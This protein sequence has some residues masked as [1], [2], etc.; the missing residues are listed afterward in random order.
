MWNETRSSVAVEILFLIDR[1]RFLL[2]AAKALAHRQIFTQSR[3]SLAEK[4]RL[5]PYRLVEAFYASS[6]PFFTLFT[7][8]L[9]V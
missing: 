4:R 9:T 1:V 3:C 6:V 5:I 2:V 8:R 7:L